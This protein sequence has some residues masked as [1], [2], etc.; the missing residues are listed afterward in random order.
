MKSRFPFTSFPNGWFQ[1]AY[2]HELPLKGVKPLH[3]FGKDLVLF[4]AEDGTPHVFD[5]HCPH[6]G[7]HLG[8]GGK[9]QGE[10][11]QC[12][13]HGWC[14]N[15]DGQCI[16]I[17]YASKIPPKAQIHTWFVR[18]INGLILVYYHDRKEPPTWEMPELPE[19]NSTEWVPFYRYVAQSKLRTH[20]QELGEQIVDFRHLPVIH[21]PNNVFAK[22]ES[23]YVDG[24]IRCDLIKTKT[25]KSF[26]GKLLNQSEIYNVETIF[27]GLGFLLQ[28]FY[29]SSRDQVDFFVL[30]SFTPIDEEYVDIRQVAIVK[31]LFNQAITSA[32]AKF[33][34]QQMKKQVD[35]DLPIIE[36]KLYHSCPLLCEGDGEIMQYRRWASQFYPEMSATTTKIPIHQQL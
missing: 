4:R 22:A 9:V 25:K 14:F 24:P 26:V 8:Y 2:S 27:Y 34:N 15:G 17:P 5:A 33:I 35:L 21:D 16:D 30:F 3:Y 28:R 10:T 6:L 11:I 19:C 18:E 13:F 12:P 36:N 32:F 31:R 23:V 7:A 20:I 29:S 1:V